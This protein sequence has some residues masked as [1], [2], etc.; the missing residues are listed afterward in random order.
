MLTL[1]LDHQV[2]NEPG[3]RLSIERS[4][5]KEP[6]EGRIPIRGRRDQLSKHSLDVERPSNTSMIEGDGGEDAAFGAQV[7]HP[8]V[9]CGDP[10]I[11]GPPQ[12]GVGGHRVAVT[13]WNPCRLDAGRHSLCKR[14]EIAVDLLGRTLSRLVSKSVILIRMQ[15]LFQPSFAAIAND[16]IENFGVAKMHSV[17]APDAFSFAICEPTSAAVTS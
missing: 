16:W 13:A 11:H 5:T 15:G 17:F 3:R 6:E 8:I 7:R 12:L 1:C 14:G 10:A 2:S 9:E 4:T